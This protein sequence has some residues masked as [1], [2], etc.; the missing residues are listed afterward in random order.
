[1]RNQHTVLNRCSSRHV[2]ARPQ[3]HQSV[4]F[5]AGRYRTWLQAY[6][7]LPENVP[8]GGARKQVG[9]GGNAVQV[10]L[11]SMKCPCTA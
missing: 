3:V 5:P 1:M 11:D 6:T 10:S 9:T 4:H 8:A 2:A 7:P